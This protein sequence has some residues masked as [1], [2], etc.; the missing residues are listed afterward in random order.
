MFELPL[1]VDQTDLEL[2]L[3][4]VNAKGW[5]GHRLNFSLIMRRG[6]NLRI[7]A[8]LLRKRLRIL[9]DLSLRCMGW[10]TGN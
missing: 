1:G 7:Q 5:F 9:F 4:D 8:L 3:R 2:Q 10:D 6:S